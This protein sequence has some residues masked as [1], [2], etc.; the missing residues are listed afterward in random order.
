MVTTRLV[1]DALRSSPPRVRKTTAEVTPT[2]LAPNALPIAP[3]S[4]SCG[5]ALTVDLGNAIA[6]R[7]AGL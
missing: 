1:M 6:P 7:E 3:D 4:M 5:D 2:S